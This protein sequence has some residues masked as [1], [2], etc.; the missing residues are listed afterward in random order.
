MLVFIIGYG[1]KGINILTMTKF[2]LQAGRASQSHSSSNEQ[3]S[4]CHER[5]PAY[6]QPLHQEGCKGV[7]YV[8]S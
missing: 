7:D 1:V 2:H 6:T 5:L 8:S 3:Y 4:M